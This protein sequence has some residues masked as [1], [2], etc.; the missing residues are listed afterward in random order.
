MRNG[1]R[2]CQVNHIREG[3]HPNPKSGKLA[4][5]PVGMVQAVDLNDTDATFTTDVDDARYVVAACES[6]LE[7]FL[8]DETDDRPPV[9]IRA[10]LAHVQF[11]TIHPFLDGNGRVGRLLIPFLFC[12]ADV[13]REPM[14]YLSLYFKQNREEYY[15]LLGL[16]REQGDWET[17]LEFFLEGI[18]QTA[19]GA[20]ATAH[21]LVVLFQ[22]DR[23]RIQERGRA[24][25]SALRVHE[26]L[27]ERPV[28]TLQDVA[29]RT[30]LSFPA[31]SSGMKLLV[32]LGVAREL[33][34]KKRNRLFGYDQYVEILGEGTEVG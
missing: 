23:N 25:G 5:Q 6:V 17:W 34:G 15:R 2:G 1:Q 21:R 13:L 26:A 29:T 14:L 8:H 24:A 7:H 9:V 11:E 31:A 22:E 19:D 33:T 20:V 28:T 32:E 10:A 18:R 30:G 16:V 27:E 12:Q 4:S 3:A